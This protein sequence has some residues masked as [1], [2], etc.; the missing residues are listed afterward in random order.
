[1]IKL[2][3][4]LLFCTVSFQSFAQEVGSCSELKKHF[5]NRIKKKT[6]AGNADNALM[7]QYDMHFYFLDLNIE[8]D[9]TWISGAVTLE[10]TVTASTLDTFA[11]ELNSNLVIDSIEYQNQSI[12]FTRIAQMTYVPLPGIPQGDEVA[13]KISYH[14]D[15]HVVGG[16]AIGDGFG[17]DTSPSWGNE[18][19]WSLSQPYSAYEW[20]PCKQ[21]LQDKADSAWVYVTTDAANK[22]GSNGTLQGIDTG[23]AN[24]KVRYRWQIHEKIDYYLISVAVAKYVDY[25]IYAHPTA[26]VNDSVK[27]QNYIYDNPNCLPYFQSKL[28]S[29]ALVL[30]YFSDLIGLYPLHEEKYGHCMAPI[31]GGMEHQTMTTIGNPGSLRVNAHELFHQWFG[32]HVTCKTW[33]DIFINEGFAS[34]G[35][36]LCYDHFRGHPSAQAN[37]ANV[38]QDVLQDPNAMVYFTDTN[39][40]NRIFDSRLTYNKG[41]AVLHTLRFIMGDSLFFQG[42]KDFQNTYAWSTA[43]ILDLKSSM[44]VSSGMNLDDYFNQWLFGEGYPIYSVDYFSDTNY[45]YLKVDHLTSSAVTPLFKGPLELKCLSASGDTVVRL[46]ITQNS[47]TFMIPSRKIITGIEIDPENWLLNKEGNINLNPALQ[48]LGL[49]DYSFQNHIQIYPNPMGET[50]HVDTDLNDTIEYELFDL[51][52][53]TIKKGSF[54]QHLTVDTRSLSSNCYYLTLSSSAGTIQRKLVR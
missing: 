1:M 25:T 43:G 28:D 7:S 40:V 18:V 11:F 20:F 44:Q 34:Y 8:R 45:I 53:R 24:N 14:G 33:S 31:G 46:D 26:L 29:V 38:H 27:I 4:I 39:N 48:A 15:A 51:L 19:T 30:E 22:V 47:N 2:L 3:S 21:F 37:M 32:D 49:A 16:A 5:Y 50:L 12:A 6:R 10:A 35:E 54:R 42:L 23:L 17:H 52:G 13:I 41:G 36:Y 9:S